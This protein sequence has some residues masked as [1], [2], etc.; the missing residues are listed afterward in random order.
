MAL[1]KETLMTSTFIPSGTMFMDCYELMLVISR[2]RSF[3][4]LYTQVGMF[5]IQ[6]FGL[7]S[8]GHN[9]KVMTHDRS[10]CGAS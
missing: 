9:S 1:D 8:A 4:K 10:N 5:S 6:S 3:L 2:L 7:V